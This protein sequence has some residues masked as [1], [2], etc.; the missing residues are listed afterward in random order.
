VSVEQFNFKAATR[1]R[2]VTA[3]LLGKSSQGAVISQKFYDIR[4][5]KKALM[6]LSI[7]L[8]FTNRC[9]VLL[10]SAYH[11]AIAS[12]GFSLVI[13]PRDIQLYCYMNSQAALSSLL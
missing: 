12:S 4:I 8:V 5:D 6:S 1:T 9:A 11:K 10:A 13:K 2:S 7:D 3:E